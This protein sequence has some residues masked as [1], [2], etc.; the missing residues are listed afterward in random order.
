MYSLMMLVLFQSAIVVLY[1]VAGAL[2]FNRKEALTAEDLTDLDQSS[3]VA[4]VNEQKTWAKLFRQALVIFLVASCLLGVVLAATK[5]HNLLYWL[6]IYAAWFNVTNLIG[7][8]VAY[9]GFRLGAKPEWVEVQVGSITIGRKRR[10]FSLFRLVKAVLAS[11]VV[12]L[13]VYSQSWIGINTLGMLVALNLLVSSRA[14]TFRQVLALT[15]GIMTF[16]AVAIFATG[17]MIKLAERAE[18]LPMMMIVPGS[19]SPS[20]PGLMVMGLGDIILPGLIVM[21]AMR[22]AKENRLPMLTVLTIA[23]L[24]VGQLITT[25]VMIV[26][27]FPQPATVYLMPGALLGYLSVAWPKGLLKR[28]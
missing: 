20:D 19:F 12:G 8:L 10:P 25:V 24:L 2:A 14:V 22:Q 3:L 5:I 26:T 9:C 1:L 23:G 21:L 18:G 28:K 13:C 15:G 7:F 11:L 4:E 6:L 27:R 16:D 17:W